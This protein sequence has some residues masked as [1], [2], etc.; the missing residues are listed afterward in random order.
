MEYQGRSCEQRAWIVLQRMEKE[1]VRRPD[2]DIDQGLH[3]VSIRI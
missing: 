3:I 2:S 1:I